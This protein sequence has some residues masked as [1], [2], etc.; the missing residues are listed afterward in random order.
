MDACS[1]V[2]FEKGASAIFSLGT[3]SAKSFNST[4]SLFKSAIL[5]V[6]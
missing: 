1:M 5:P 6:F 4:L 3:A 2:S